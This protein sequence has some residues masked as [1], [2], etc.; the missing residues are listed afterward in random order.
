MT[1]A[2]ILFVGLAI[3]YWVLKPG[4]NKSVEQPKVSQRARSQVKAYSAASIHY[5]ENACCAVKAIGDKRFLASKAPLL[6]LPE[7]NANN[8]KC[9]YQRYDDRREQDNR[10]AP[11]SLQVDLHV[12]AGNAD[13]RSLKS[14]R[15]SD[16]GPASASDFSYDN[17]E[18]N[19]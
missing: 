9:A 11:F 12:M 17:I 18:W 3:V 4:N 2:A 8:C 10:R 5:R 16:L 19:T 1:I 6:P 14:R 15:D 13:R 7:C